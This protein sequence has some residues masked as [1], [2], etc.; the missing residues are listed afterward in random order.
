[1]K[2]RD[3][4]AFLAVWLLVSVPLGGPLAAQP[5]PR[6]ALIL[7]QSDPAAPFNIA[8]AS[9]IRSTLIRS[10]AA[11]VSVYTEYLDFGAFS[12]AEYEKVLSKYLRAKYK[13]KA[14]GVIVV[15][16][17]TT[18][19]FMLRLRS[20]L[21]SEVP[22]VFAAV[23]V[24]TIARVNLP[25][26]VTGTTMA[27]SLRDGVAAAR[28]LV[29]DLKRIAL[30]GDPLERQD[31]RPHFKEEIPVFATELQFID[32]TGLPMTELRKRVAQLPEHTVIIYTAIYDGGEGVVYIP[33]DALVAIAE[34]ANRPIVVD[35]GVHIGYGATGGFVVD[36]DPIAQETG[37]LVLR[38]IN[39]ESASQIPVETRNF[40]RP[41]FDW[42]QLKRWN[43]SEST[44]P[45]GSEV[46]FGEVTAWD[47]Y[48]W[49]IILIA[50]VLAIQT[51]LLFGLFY[52]HRRRRRAEAAS[53]SAMG[54]LAHMNRL[55]TADELTAA[56]AHEVGQP[57][58]AMV[59]NAAAGL[60]WLTNKT[61][62]LDKA[63]ATMTNVV[64]AGHRAGEVIKGVRA[65]FKKDR[66]EKT[67]VDLNVV[68]E[69]VLALLREELQT[70]RIL[71][72]TQLTSPL[73][74]VLGQSG[75]LQQVILNLVRNS[76]DAMESVSGR[77]RV[78]RLKTAI[79]NPDGVLVSVEDSGTGIDPNDIDRIFETFFTTKSQGMG[80]GL[81]ICRSIIEA[82][83]GK[84]W[85]SSGAPNGSVFN[86]LLQPIRLPQWT[87]RQRQ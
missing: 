45:P 43:I 33:R 25:R 74:L 56:I 12:G 50:T 1:M 6:S 71:V 19:E 72:Q 14:L 39:G 9:T 84:L 76:A 8:F 4:I 57:L 41:V 51:A 32:L 49:Q 63:R 35:Q 59:T 10:S 34:V 28:A 13:G 31:F 67:P 47:Q 46:R 66:Q 60:R 26:D 16:G 5:L 54:K 48:S 30:V 65:M 87:V 53:R 38:I 3:F 81:S 70:R 55:A 21:W 79:H 77:A 44:L 20:E 52:E 69:D 68:I 83:D 15:I 36:P 2:R 75:Q 11:P 18:L 61:P 27:I 29:P 42:R 86:I 40:T 62:D 17:S 64:D 7:Y 24:K 22:V 23:D 85:A 80:M 78:L 82:H 73:P 37:Q 58:T